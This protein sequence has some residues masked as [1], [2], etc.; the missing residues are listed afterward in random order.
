M[1]YSFSM[2]TCT[3]LNLFSTVG[4]HRKQSWRTR[5]RLRTRQK[6]YLHSRVLSHKQDSFVRCF[7][8]VPPVSRI[9][10]G[11]ENAYRKYGWKLR[12][13]ARNV[14]P[15]GERARWRGRGRGRKEEKKKYAEQRRKLVIESAGC[16]KCGVKNTVVLDPDDQVRYLPVLS[17]IPSNEWSC[18]RT[19]RCNQ[20]TTCSLPV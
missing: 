10:A 3:S 9:P 18:Y 14:V 12:N 8:L 7:F 16:G 17:G 13:N 19:P 6:I 1:L 11:R 5:A 4:D 2:K 15:W 20:P